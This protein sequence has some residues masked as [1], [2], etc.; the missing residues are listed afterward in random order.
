HRLMREAAYAPFRGRIFLMADANGRE[1]RVALSA[2]PVFDETSGRF[3]GY[4]GTGIDVTSRVEA[5]ERARAYQQELE[6]NLDQL[7]ER[8]MQ[9]DVAL[10]EARA[11]A[12]A[13]TEFL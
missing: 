3:T 2:V 1:R 9:L 13:K 11:A 6:G 8:N 4:R 12:R 7:R 10:E 5:T